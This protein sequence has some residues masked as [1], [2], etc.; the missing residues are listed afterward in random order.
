MYSYTQRILRYIHPR[1]AGGRILGNL[2]IVCKSGPNC[3]RVCRAL[4][5]SSPDHQE[6][7]NYSR[8][9]KTDVGQNP[10]YKSSIT[11]SNSLNHLESAD[12]ISRSELSAIFENGPHHINQ[13]KISSIGCGFNILTATSCCS[14]QLLVACGQYCADSKKF[15]LI[16]LYNT[17]EYYICCTFI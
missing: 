1:D 8:M 3:P 15:H 6:G 17:F 13:L 12:V 16:L 7:N 9:S 2:C 4:D 5:R 10:N 11:F 14:N